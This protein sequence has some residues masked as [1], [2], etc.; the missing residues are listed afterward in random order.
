MHSCIC[1]VFDKH[2]RLTWNP[3]IERLGVT[4][5]KP[6]GYELLPGMKRPAD[7]EDTESLVEPS[8]NKKA[9]AMTGWGNFMGVIISSTII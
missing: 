9:T 5:V 4:N 2:G 6:T 8:P 7:N 1:R 3:F